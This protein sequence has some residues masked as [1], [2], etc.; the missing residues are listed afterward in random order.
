MRL[1]LTTTDGAMVPLFRIGGEG[2]LIDHA[3]E[4]GRDQGLLGYRLRAGRVLVPP[5]SRA[6]IVAAIPQGAA[7]RR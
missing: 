1:H 5:G 6:D 7:A 4:R 3:V 2:G